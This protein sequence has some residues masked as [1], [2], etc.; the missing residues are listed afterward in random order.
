MT[1]RLIYI[2][3]QTILELLK[4]YLGE[5]NIPANAKT[6]NFLFKPNERGA[7]AI[8]FESPDIKGGQASLVANFD[9]KR[10]F[11]ISGSGGNMGN[12]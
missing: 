9:V 1:D 10:N 5:E 8:E 2:T 6:V 4:D 12:V 7:L 3:H 11:G